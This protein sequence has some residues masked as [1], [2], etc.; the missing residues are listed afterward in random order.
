MTYS[1][2]NLPV[3]R[4][5]DGNPTISLPTRSESVYGVELKPL[6]KNPL[7][8][9]GNPLT[10]EDW[11]LAQTK[12]PDLDYMMIR[13]PGRGENQQ[14][15]DFRFMVNPE[16]IQVGSQVVD[17]Q[18]MTRGGWQFGVWGEDLLQIHMRG[19]SGGYYFADG[20]TEQDRLGSVNFRSMLEL[21]NLFEN[22]GYWF[23]GEKYHKEDP[24]LKR[25]LIQR[26]EDIVLVYNNFIWYGA[27]D[28]MTVSTT[29]ESPFLDNFDFNFTAWKERFR[30]SSPYRDSIHN[31]VVR[32]HSY[33]L[34][35][36]MNEELAL[37]ESVDPQTLRNLQTETTPPQPNINSDFLTQK[38]VI[39]PPFSTLLTPFSM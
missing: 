14:F 29:S 8:G 7:S 24:R 25:K 13:V 39:N 9:Q 1:L 21:R 33:N 15:L 22:N 19:K 36:L 27:F 10:R 6:S 4:P 26:H 34:A 16:F 5:L 37:I 11:N 2:N 28:S 32:G 17:S 12:T 35:H 20:V 23:E 3:T 30:Y 31:N 38:T 18:S